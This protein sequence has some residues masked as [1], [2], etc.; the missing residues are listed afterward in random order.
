MN[1]WMLVRMEQW[2]GVG[3]DEMNGWMLVR[4]E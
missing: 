3:E 4:M 2:V 1:G